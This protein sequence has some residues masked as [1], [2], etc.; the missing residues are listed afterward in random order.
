[1]RLGYAR[2]SRKGQEIEQQVTALRAADC[3]PIF[4]ETASGAKEDRPELAKMMA[5]AR[6]GDT[7]V[8]WKL[9]RLAR[10]MRHLIDIAADLQ[11]RGIHLHS[12]TDAIDTSTASGELHFHMLSALAQFE[13]GLII[14]RV[15]AGLRVA[16]ASGSKSGRKRADHPDHVVKLNRALAMIRGGLRPVEAARAVGISR[17]TVYKYM[18]DT[19]KKTVDKKTR[20]KTT[21]NGKEANPG[22]HSTNSANE[23][24]CRRV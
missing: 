8:I 22:D 21:M 13:R 6:A 20:K 15:N 24:I 4:T 7:I 17:A 3:D 23:V 5:M 19:D 16:W 2:V 9:D 10:S 1:M 14:E 11:T 18:A 12:L